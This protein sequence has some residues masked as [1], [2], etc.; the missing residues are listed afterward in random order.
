MGVGVI[1]TFVDHEARPGKAPSQGRDRRLRGSLSCPSPSSKTIQL[2][3]LCLAVMQQRR[4]STR[5]CEGQNAHR[6]A[7]ARKGI[8]MFLSFPSPPMHTFPPL[9]HSLLHPG[10]PPPPPRSHTPSCTQS[11][12]HSVCQPVTLRNGNLG[13]SPTTAV[14]RKRRDNASLPMLRTVWTVWLHIRFPDAD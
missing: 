10:L 14:Q 11:L 4:K 12:L 5:D 2:L 7:L 6:T 13:F 3:G 9:T 8:Y 1:A